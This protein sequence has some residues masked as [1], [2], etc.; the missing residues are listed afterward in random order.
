MSRKQ[1][2]YNSPALSKARDKYLDSL[3]EEQSKTYNTQTKMETNLG[4][5]KELLHTWRLSRHSSSGIPAF[6]ASVALDTDLKIRP[7]VFFF[8]KKK[9]IGN[10]ILTVFDKGTQ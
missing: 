5:K 7:N 10:H 4:K 6:A 1:D 9:S 8:N 2:V 3:E